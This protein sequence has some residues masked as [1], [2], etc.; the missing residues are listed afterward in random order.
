MSRPSCEKGLISD[1]WAEPSQINL[2]YLGDATETRI[3]PSNP[4]DTSVA[5]HPPHLGFAAFSDNWAVR[6]SGGLGQRS[7]TWLGPGGPLVQ[8]LLMVSAP[9]FLNTDNRSHAVDEVFRTA[10]ANRRS[11]ALAWLLA[12]GFALVALIGT[13]RAATPSTFSEELAAFF[14]VIGLWISF[15]NWI[16][17]KTAIEISI[18]S[19]RYRSPLRTIVLAWDEIDELWAMPSGSSWRIEVRGRGQAFRFR[20]R[21]ELRVG[22]RSVQIGFPDGE[23]LAGLIVGLAGLSRPAGSTGGWVCTRPTGESE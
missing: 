19:L 18:D 23:R 15:G 14:G 8:S 2:S 4:P 12:L 7:D 11:E 22:R 16:D 6:R 20:T 10:P 13:A 1:G 9:G 21:S 17:R 3:H 5:S